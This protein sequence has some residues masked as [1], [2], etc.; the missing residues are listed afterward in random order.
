MSGLN[1][2]LEEVAQAF[3][4]S[5]AGLHVVRARRNTA[6]SV[7]IFLRMCRGAMPESAFMAFTGVDLMYHI[8]IL[9]GIGFMSS[10][11][12]AEFVQEIPVSS[13]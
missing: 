6:L 9:H 3:H 7:R 11:L 1:T 12:R 2:H 4:Q 8:E 10:G 5:Y 13:E